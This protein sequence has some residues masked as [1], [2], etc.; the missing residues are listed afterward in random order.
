MDKLSFDD[1]SRVITQ[2]LADQNYVVS[3]DRSTTKLFIVVYW[4]TTIAPEDTSPKSGRESSQLTEKANSLDGTDP[5]QAAAYRAEASS[6]RPMESRIDNQVDAQSANLLGYTDELLRTSPKD[7]QRLTLQDEIEEDRYYVV[8]LA[9]DYQLARKTMQHKLLWET[10]FSIPERG[11]DFDKAFPLMTSIAAKY[12]GQDS[13]GLIH[14][15]LGEGHVEIGE[16][17]SLGALPEK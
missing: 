9:Y 15:N 16:P 7:P 5:G 6:F 2:P 11:T 4:G 3:G 17:Q 14:H 12:F 1:V 13:H 8:L 10:R